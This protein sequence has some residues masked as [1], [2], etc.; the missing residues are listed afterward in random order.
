MLKTS[1]VY[2]LLLLCFGALADDKLPNLLFLKDKQ[3]S[4]KADL[5]VV[6]WLAGHW[7]GEAFG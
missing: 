4:P 3:Q 6:K 7:R 1:T 2:L 5:S